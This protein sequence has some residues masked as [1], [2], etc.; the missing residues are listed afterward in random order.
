MK[1]IFI[2]RRDFRI[3][4]NTGLIECIKN[5]DT[6][7]PIFIFTPEQIKN[8]DYKSDNAVQFMIT[9]LKYL[10]KKIDM[11]FCYGDYVKV[12]KEMVKKYKIDSI[13]TNTDYTKY[14]IKR[15]KDI[16]KLAKDLGIEF[17]YFD[18]ICL[19]KPGTVLTGGKKIYQKFTPFYNTCLTIKVE[20]PKRI[21]L[22]NGMIKKANFKY[23]INMSE[24][25]KYYKHND[26]I[27]IDGGRKEGLKIL[28]NL[29]K[30]KKYD[31]TRNTLSIETTQLSGYLKFGCVSIR[32]CYH[33]M[34]K[35]FGKKDPLIRQLIWRDFYYHLGNGFIDRFGKSLKPKYDNI[36]WDYNASRL[37]KWKDGNTGYPVVDACMKQINNTGYMH[38]R[39]RLI[40]A[41]FLVKN[42]QINW[43]QGEKY[44]AQKLLDY[45]VLVNN[46][47]WQ[48]VSGSGADSMPYFRIFNPWT[49]SEKFD[50]KCEYIKHWLPNL[51]D[52]ENKHL[53]QWEKF[54]TEYDL[55]EIDYVK[56]MIDYKES[57]EKTL[58]M[59]KKGLY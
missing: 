51:K 24:M 19:F 26:N 9:S 43:E 47:N 23:S 58:K 10:A 56:P 53:H 49:Q 12:L 20:E 4:D 5:S 50:P 28:K 14:A 8:N 34:K 2:F 27:N 3:T 6:V 59:Y 46:G 36:K 45:D 57:R 22:D 41:S 16:V 35:K 55:K 30:F 44:F 31:D 13:Y 18:D 42:L 7:Y 37:Q 21:N 33:K 1:S 32:E 17:K 52:V 40:V 15:E 48:W 39:G 38:N 54:Y 25:N 29:D 11:T